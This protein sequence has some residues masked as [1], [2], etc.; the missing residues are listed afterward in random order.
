M[1]KW[2][3]PVVLIAATACATSPK[4]VDSD[5]FPDDGNL[6]AA[7][8]L[9]LDDLIA[10]RVGPAVDDRTDWKTFQL[11][12]ASRVEVRFTAA[13]AIGLNVYEEDGAHVGSLTGGGGQNQAFVAN[14]S[15]GRYL[16]E[17]SAQGAVSPI[18]YTLEVETLP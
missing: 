18:D 1:A 12:S 8:P 15:A 17:I 4:L 9:E 2:L 7:V 14:L 13:G 6:T 10:D 3:I 5:P 11:R 16:V